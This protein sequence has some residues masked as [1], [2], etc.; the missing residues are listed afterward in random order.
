MG[1]AVHK[2]IEL[3]VLGLEVVQRVLQGLDEM[4]ILC[5]MAFEFN[6]GPLKVPDQVGNL[7]LHTVHDPH[8]C[9][10]DNN[11][12]TD[13]H[14]RAPYEETK[15]YE[16]QRPAR[17][18]H[19]DGASH[20]V[21]KGDR[22]RAQWRTQ[23]PPRLVLCY[24]MLIANNGAPRFVQHTDTHHIFVRQ[25]IL[26]ESS[27]LLR[28]ILPEALVFHDQVSKAHS[29]LMCVDRCRMPH[30]SEPNAVKRRREPKADTTPDEQG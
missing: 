2:A 7:P 20:T 8:R 27:I 19:L 26:Q 23:V 18:V 11:C 24:R 22:G 9:T 17:D 15:R 12:Q 5:G 1:H 6:V 30:S 16:D 4:S 25:E 21:I 13:T 10:V 28:L 14:G 29:Q 3:S